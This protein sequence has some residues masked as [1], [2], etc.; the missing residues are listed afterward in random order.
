V[1]AIPWGFESPVPHHSTRPCRPRSEST[2]ASTEYLLSARDDDIVVQMPW[3]YFL[4][5]AD[6]SLYVGHADDLGSR[7]RRHNE[8]HGATFTAAR[9]PVHVV[10]SEVYDCHA[11][12]L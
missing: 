7:V 10:Y 3:V 1:G 8:G 4:R 2:G 12:A 5:C 11:D 9:L 6:N